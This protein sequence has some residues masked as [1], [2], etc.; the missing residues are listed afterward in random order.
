MKS[1]GLSRCVYHCNHQRTTAFVALKAFDDADSLLGKLAS[2]AAPVVAPVVKAAA[3]PV[4]AAVK[5]AAPAVVAPVVEAMTA[6]APSVPTDIPDVSAVGDLPILPIAL[7]V[8]AVAAA[9]TL[10]GGDK[11]AEEPAPSV[12]AP[13]VPAPA[14][15]V[16]LETVDL[17]IPYD[18]AAR[19]AYDK[20]G[21]PGDYEAFKTKYETDAVADVKAKK[22]KSKAK[23]QKKKE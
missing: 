12:S 22:Q 3:P 2:G 1:H 19:L 17:S 10:L 5:A 4:T 13:S 6:V 11:A 15:V 14:P 8:L 18:A 23:K 20:A 7:I 16:V 21:Q 9:V